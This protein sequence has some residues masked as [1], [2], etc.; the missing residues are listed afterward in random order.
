MIIYLTKAVLR[1]RVSLGIQKAVPIE[2]KW[3]VDGQGSTQ[4]HPGRLG[5]RND[6]LYSGDVRGRQEDR[7]GI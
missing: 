3:A 5:C 6:R 1:R 4:A 2:G 7:C